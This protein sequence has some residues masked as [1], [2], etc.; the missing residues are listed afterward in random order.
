MGDI[1]CLDELLERPVACLKR[2]GKEKNDA[3]SLG[4]EKWEQWW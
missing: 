1:V 2:C 3:T 4:P